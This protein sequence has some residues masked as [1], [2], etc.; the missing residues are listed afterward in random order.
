MKPGRRAF[1]D[2]GAFYALIDRSDSFHEAAVGGF[3]RAAT[4]H[5]VLLTT[6]LVVGEAFTLIQRKLGQ[7]PAV[8]WLRSVRES[9]VCVI[10]PPTPIGHQATGHPDEGALAV[11]LVGEARRNSIELSVA[12]RQDPALKIAPRARACGPGPAG[13]R[14]I[15][16]SR[17]R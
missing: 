13:C 2:T 1:V 11:G 16:R 17:A 5:L 8:V 7:R 6:I 10:W 14:R 12:M 15:W 4:G 9:A 3:R